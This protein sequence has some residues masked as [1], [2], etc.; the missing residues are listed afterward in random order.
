MWIEIQIIR[1]EDEPDWGAMGVKRPRKYT[2]EI[3]VNRL[4]Y[5]DSIIWV[6]ESAEGC[7]MCIVDEDQPLPLKNNYREMVE[8]IRNTEPEDMDL[9]E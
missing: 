9:S 5:L 1:G 4:I 7:I 6:E 8:L 3:I 2:G